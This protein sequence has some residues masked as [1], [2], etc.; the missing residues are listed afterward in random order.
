MTIM[1]SA[2]A[3]NSDYVDATLAIGKVNLFAEACYKDYEINLKE[4]ALKVL[5]ESGTEEDF[6]FLATEA[7]NA[8]IEKAKKSIEKII[9][10]IKKFI[11]QCKEKVLSMVRGENTMKAIKKAEMACKTNPK[12]CR[13]KVH[14]QDTDKQVGAIQQGIDNIRKK[15]TK[16][17]VGK[18]SE[19]D[20]EELD[21][22]EESTAKK[23]AAVSVASVITLGTAIA[24]YKKTTKELN[25]L[26]IEDID[27]VS[28]IGKEVKEG[29]TAEAAH[30][31]VKASGIIGKLKKERVSKKVAKLVS[32]L[33]G[34][35][36]TVSGR[37]GETRSENLETE[38]ERLEDLKMF[39][40]VTMESAEELEENSSVEKVEEESVGEVEG[41]DLDQYYE[42]LCNDLFESL[43]DDTVTESSNEETEETFVEESSLTETYMEQMER[44]LFGETEEVVEES[45][46]EQVLKDV[47]DFLNEMENLFE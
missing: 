27:D 1:E 26:S 19:K 29:I 32:L 6:M 30:A 34:I 41:L 45:A 38:S 31:F 23:V 42:E 9:E 33:S 24:L 35:K 4:S 8:Y 10:S 47:D 11:K 28:S 3:M 44:E 15:T 16:L 25:N 18:G 37:S 14:Y 46:S 36:S 43:E 13:M 39:E 21:K 40:V 2:I 17:K 5:K 20:I 22:I 7:G 12:I